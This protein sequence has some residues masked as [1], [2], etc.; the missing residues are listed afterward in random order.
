MNELGFPHQGMGFAVVEFASKKDAQKA[1]FGMKY[2]N[3]NFETQADLLNDNPIMEY[4]P[5]F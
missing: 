3:E 1:I 4:F 5:E 2:I